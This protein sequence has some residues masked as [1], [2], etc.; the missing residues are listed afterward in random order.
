MSTELK[1]LEFTPENY[2][3]GTLVKFCAEECSNQEA[4]KIG[5]QMASLMTEAKGLGLAANQVGYLL[6]LIVLLIKGKCVVLFKPKIEKIGK[7]IFILEEGC[8]SLPGI[9]RK[10]SRPT[11]V[12]FSAIINKSG[13][14]KQFELW[15]LEARAFF[16]EWDHTQGMTILDK[17][18]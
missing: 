8:L 2:K 7:E 1:I 11:S 4:F 5:K 15:D 12:V 16:H 13:K 14:R 18:K 9:K 17:R 10:I 6:P 3:M